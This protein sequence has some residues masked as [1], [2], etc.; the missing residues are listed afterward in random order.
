MKIIYQGI[1]ITI[2][3]IE[4]LEPLP[5]VVFDK[6]IGDINDDYGQ[7]HIIEQRD[8]TGSIKKTFIANTGSHTPLTADSM[9]HKNEAIYFCSGKYV[10]KWDIIKMALNWCIELDFC[11][12]FTLQFLENENSILVSGESDL[13]KIDLNGNIL[14]Q[15]SGSDIF[16]TEQGK[17][18]AQVIEN[19]IYITDWNNIL[20]VLDF[21]G[22]LVG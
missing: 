18:G 11:T 10:C 9:L 21:E 3:A 2:N 6:I 5:N 16:V 7:R 4:T 19:K 17:N 22:N 20:Y 1:E 13:S 12:C 14:W 8:V 15:Y